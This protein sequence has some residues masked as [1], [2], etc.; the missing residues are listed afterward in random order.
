MTRFAPLALSAA[1]SLTLGCAGAASPPV[2]SPSAPVNAE[3]APGSIAVTSQMG[4][5]HPGDQAPDFELVDQ[6]GATVKLSELRGSVVVLAFVTSAD[7]RR[8]DEP[9]SPARLTVRLAIAPGYHV[10]S[11]RPCDPFS[12]PTTVGASGDGLAFGAAEFPAAKRRLALGLRWSARG[13]PPGPSGGPAPSRASVRHRR[14]AVPGVHRYAVPPARPEA[15]RS[16]GPLTPAHLA[17]TRLKP[18]ERDEGFDANPFRAV[19]DH[20]SSR[21]RCAFAHRCR[22]GETVGPRAQ[23][24]PPCG[25]TCALRESP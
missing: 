10:M 16:R 11:D 19:L 24:E 14:C 12:I 15:H 3:A 6:H 25:T 22:P 4:S 21:K 2:A 20:R 8:S 9:G 7:L 18:R 13:S 23:R 5:P 17:R 1:L